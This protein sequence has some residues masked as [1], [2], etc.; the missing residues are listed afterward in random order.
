M[1]AGVDAKDYL[2]VILTHHWPFLIEYLWLFKIHILR[3]GKNVV[4][5]KVNC[6]IV[7]RFT[8]SVTSFQFNSNRASQKCF[9][10]QLCEKV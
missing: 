3:R 7:D 6:K 1:F 10:T 9:S 4:H 5:V 8:A 2:R